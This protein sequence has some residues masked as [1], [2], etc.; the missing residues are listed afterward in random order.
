MRVPGECSFFNIKLI[1]VTY[2][3][4]LYPQG[5]ALWLKFCRYFI[6]ISERKEERKRGREGTWTEE[7][8]DRMQFQDL[9]V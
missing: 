9:I 8:M 3:F 5:L 4:P 1:K 2:L 7:K 6:N